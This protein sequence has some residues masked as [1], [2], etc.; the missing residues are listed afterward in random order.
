M[1]YDDAIKYISESFNIWS[2]RSNFKWELNI[3]YLKEYLQ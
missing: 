3:D 1:G 2:K